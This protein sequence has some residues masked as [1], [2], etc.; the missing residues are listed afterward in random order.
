MLYTV[1][2]LCIESLNFYLLLN[3]SVNAPIVASNSACIVFLPDD[4]NM[5]SEIPWLSDTSR[6]E[7]LGFSHRCV[8]SHPIDIQCRPIRNAII[9]SGQTFRNA[10]EFWDIVYM[11][12]LPGR[13]LYRFKKNNLK[14]M[15][16]VFT[17][18]KCPWRITC[19]PIS[20]S[21]VVQVHT[22]K[23]GHNHSLYDVASSQPSIKDKRVS[24]MIDDVIRSTLDYQPRQIC[25][26]FVR[27]HGLRLSYNQAWNLKEKAKERIYGIPKNYYKLLPWM[28]E[29]IFQTNPGIIVELT[30]SNDGHFE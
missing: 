15:S 8:E 22:F 10:N 28:C 9:G 6:I 24:K 30:H 25:K 3:S 5:S 23:I 27:Q 18:E 16:V 11:M 7:S 14:Q 2:M 26:D 17:I 13:F 4:D 19:R 21:K 29:R 1:V 12:S 20:S